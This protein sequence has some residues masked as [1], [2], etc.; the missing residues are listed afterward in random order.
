[1]LNNNYI[2]DPVTSALCVLIYLILT[3]ALPILS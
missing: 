3:I 1:M 2:L